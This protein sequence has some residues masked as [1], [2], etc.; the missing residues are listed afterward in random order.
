[1]EDFPSGPARATTGWQTLA[2]GL[3]LAVAAGLLARLLAGVVLTWRLLR[4]SQPITEEWA[5]GLDVRMGAAITTPVA[6]GAAVLLPAGC[7]DWSPANRRAVLAHEQSHIARG[8]VYVLLLAALH[9]AIFW[10]SPFS[11]WLL[12]ELAETAELVSDD[13]AIEALGDRQAYAEILLDIAR[14]TR[15]VA[16][17]IAM[18]RTRNVLI[19]VDR[20]L[21]VTAP[22]PLRLDPG[23]LALIAVSL[24]PLIALTAVSFA[25]QTGPAGSALQ[26]RKLAGAGAVA[27]TPGSPKLWILGRLPPPSPAD[28]NDMFRMDA[29]WKTVAAQTSVVKFLPGVLLN[30]KDE[31]LK[32]AFEN[33]AARH[34]AL[35]LEMG[36]LVRTGQCTQKTKAYSNPGDVERMLERAQRLG[37][38]PKYIVI[39]NPFFFGHRFLAPDACRE[40]AEELARQIAQ[41]I[42]LIRSYFP[43]VEIGASDTVDESSAWVGELASWTDVYRRVT[44]EPLA[45]FHAEMEWSRPAVQNLAA[46]AGEMKARGIPFGIT[47]DGDDDASSNEAWFDSAR[48]HIA[49]IESVIGLRPDTAIFKTSFNH[50]APLVPETQPGTLTNLASQYL[51]ARPSMTLTWQAGLASG[52]VADAQGRP[53]ASAGM[54]VE[55]LDVA[56]SLELTEHR[57]NGKVPANAAAALAGIFVGAGGSCVCAGPA[58]AS[59]G[60]L[61]YREDRTGV[62]EEILPALSAAGAGHPTVRLHLSP[63]EFF[64]LTLKLFPVTPGSDYHLDA[65]LSVTASG[66]H[67]GNIAELFLDGSG[68]E[69]RRDRLWFRPS[70]LNLGTPVTDSDGRFQLQIPPR[71]GEAGAMIRAYFPGSGTLAFQTVT[72]SQTEQQDLIAVNAGARR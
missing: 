13:A 36:L 17:G 70:V 20:I 2:I 59:I 22:P 52:Q 33:L 41:K 40:P 48:Q 1:L 49:E 19:R 51:L 31:N 71:I 27:E 72:V 67:A 35:A 55:A 58:D 9:R 11:W 64:V 57:L 5:A 56:G 7:L 68:K 32:R 29:A 23:R 26:P 4:G 21:A 14:S 38:D 69:I 24:A 65:P 61:R 63:G 16:A 50:L 43:K 34:I 46:L 66:D 3:Y 47:Y 54:T 39:V 53:L 25:K 42:Q 30:R 45:F 12:N 8:D 18:A 6:A 28:T 62:N 37:A 10:F 15:R 44:G 60:T